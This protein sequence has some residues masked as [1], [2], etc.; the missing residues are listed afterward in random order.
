MKPR[1]FV[2][3][4]LIAA[5]LAS[6]LLAPAAPAADVPVTLIAFNVSWHIGTEAGAPQPNI[7]ATAGD[8]LR[9]RVENHDGFMH[10]FTLP[11]FSVDQSLAAGSSANPTVAFVNITTTAGDVGRWQFYCSVPGHTT[12]SDPNRSGMVGWVRVDAPG[13]SVSVTL[14][15]YTTAWHVA[16]HDAPAK[17]TITVNPGDVLR[18]RVENHD[19]FAH[20]FTFD[21]F[22]VDVPLAAGS[23]STP[24]VV[25]VNITTST[26]DIGKWQFYCSVPGHTTGTG[27]SR[28]GMVGWVQVGAVRP[29]PTPGFEVVLVVAALGIVAIAARIVPRRKA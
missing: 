13:P 8:V 2:V 16:A 5:L 3:A 10:T 12:G 15:A 11:H 14:I 19:A 1:V 4:A 28:D 18:F 6:P 29:P 17:P 22:A 20:A 21:H 24:T 7:T 26:A 25:F 23:P 27:E 9:L